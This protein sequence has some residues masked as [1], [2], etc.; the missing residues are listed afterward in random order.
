DEI[1]ASITRMDPD[2]SNH[3]IF[4]QGIRNTVGFD[5]HPE[6][7]ELWFTDNGRDWMGD[8]EPPDELNR[9]PQSGLHFGYPF[10]HGG[11]LPDPKFGDQRNCEEFVSPVQNLGPHVAALGMKFYT[12]NMFPSEYKQQV[13]IAEH[14]SWNRAT[15]IGYRIMLVKLDGNRALSYEPFAEG[16]LQGSRAWGRPV[17]ILQI[18]DG[19]LLVSDDAANAIY[20]I[21]Y[22]SEPTQ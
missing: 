15:P 5:W 6:T 21:S 1:F 7:N 20:R 11:D 8:N 18:S 14:G 17:D 13:F 3:E 12:G 10:C 19:S 16:W 22:Q 9:A 4:A 2:G